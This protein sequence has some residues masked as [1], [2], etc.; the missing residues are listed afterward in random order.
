MST[1]EIIT[2]TNRQEEVNVAKVD[3]FWVTTTV[4][5]LSGCKDVALKWF[6][7]D[8]KR[9]VAPY[10]SVIA[11]YHKLRDF[12]RPYSERA[13]DERFTM[14]EAEALI[15]YLRKHHAQDTHTIKKVDLPLPMETMCYSGLSVGGPNGFLE[16]SK[17]P[18]WPL[19][20]RVTGYYDLRDHEVLPGGE[21]EYSR[22][23]HS[24]K[25]IMVEG[26]VIQLSD[27]PEPFRTR[28]W[29]HN[30]EEP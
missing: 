12:F 17:R 7:L 22:A 27:L 28:A 25:F 30:S 15:T 14:L 2:A 11:D 10:A 13:A 1:I 20:F 26:G 5:R 8:R 29:Q 16:L 19:W 6:A 9:P 4:A 21:D 24:N 18:D 3:L 23:A